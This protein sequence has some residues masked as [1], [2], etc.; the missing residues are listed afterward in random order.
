MQNSSKNGR[1]IE[2]SA[3]SELYAELNK[4][5][6]SFEESY[7]K[8]QYNIKFITKIGETSPTQLKKILD[9]KFT[10]DL[11]RETAIEDRK[12]EIK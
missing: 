3:I 4:T 8:N 12:D 2:N 10:N 6:L 1:K 7:N 9:E 11:L 5:N